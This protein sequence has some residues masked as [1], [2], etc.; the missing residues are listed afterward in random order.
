ML[1]ENAIDVDMPLAIE[2][3]VVKECRKGYSIPTGLLPVGIRELLTFRPRNFSKWNYT[4]YAPW[5]TTDL[6]RHLSDHHYF[7]HPGGRISNGK[8]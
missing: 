5:L 6:L 4:T 2:C 3:G 7:V 8:A 1:T